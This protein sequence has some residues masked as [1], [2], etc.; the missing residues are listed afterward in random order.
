MRHVVAVVLRL[1]LF[2]LVWAALGSWQADYVVYGLVG[3][4]AAT[5]L[6][7]ALVPPAETRVGRWPRR[8]LGVTVLAGWFLRR[9]VQGGLDVAVR[10]VR[11]PPAVDPMVLKAPLRLPPGHA[12][13]T[14]LL[15]MNLM[16]GSMVQRVVGGE[17]EIH[18]LSGD[19]RPDLQWDALQH[20]V[21]AA[22]GVDV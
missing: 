3:V 12:R 4:G 8:V 18:T 6:S 11:S 14:A 16:P 21:G 9:A 2:A 20:R 5:A 13:E 17:V 7:L 15:L 10:A 1:L 22:F 19:L